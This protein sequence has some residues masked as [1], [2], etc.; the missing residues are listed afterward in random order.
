[1]STYNFNT[2]SIWQKMGSVESNAPLQ[3]PCTPTK[4][5]AC[6]TDSSVESKKKLKLSKNPY[7][8]NVLP[9]EM[10]KIMDASEKEEYFLSK[11]AEVYGSYV[12]TKGGCV[13]VHLMLYFEWN[14]LHKY[15]FALFSFNLKVE[16]F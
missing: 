12:P 13:G 2:S 14:E 5:A 4:L 16:K 7:T 11:K 3:A 9:Q 15:V 8:F 1:M 10:V 6:H